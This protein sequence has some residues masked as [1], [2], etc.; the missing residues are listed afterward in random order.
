MDNLIQVLEGVQ[1]EHLGE[2]EDAA[3]SRATWFLLGVGAAL[4]GP[5]ALKLVTAGGDF[6]ARRISKLNGL[7]GGGSRRRR[8]R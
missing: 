6:A 2:G 1:V 5:M 7:S 4:L 8:R 3:P